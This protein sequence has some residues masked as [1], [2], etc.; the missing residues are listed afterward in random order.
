MDEEDEDKE[1]DMDEVED[2][3]EEDVG[4]SCSGCRPFGVNL[5]SDRWLE[6]L[7]VAWFTKSLK[8]AFLS[9]S[10]LVALLSWLLMLRV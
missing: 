10:L 2:D 5:C 9:L 4:G 6:L 1:R 7:L 3:R 8:L